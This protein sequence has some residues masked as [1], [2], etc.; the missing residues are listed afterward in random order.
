MSQEE[1]HW[2]EK[3][4][5]GVEKDMQDSKSLQFLQYY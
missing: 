3:V 5:D 1:K 2:H 4:E